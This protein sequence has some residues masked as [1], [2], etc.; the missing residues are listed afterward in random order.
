VHGYGWGATEVAELL[1]VNVSTVRSHVA[2]ALASLRD[3][4]EVSSDAVHD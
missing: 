2:R 3:A 4:L 1:E